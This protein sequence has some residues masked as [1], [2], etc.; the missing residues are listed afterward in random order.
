MAIK[1]LKPQA[2]INT[3]E[4]TGLEPH[5]QAAP[6]QVPDQAALW[7]AAQAAAKSAAAQAAVAQGDHSPQHMKAP[8][9]P[10]KPASFP[11]L[12][13]G[14]EAKKALA[15]EEAKTEMRQRGYIRRWWLPNGKDGSI[16][17]LDGSLQDGMLDIPYYYE[18]NLFINGKYGNFFLCLQD[19]EPC[20]ICQQNNIASYVGVMS[21]IDH[22]EYVSHDGKV[23]KDQRSLFVAKR[24]TVKLLQKIAATC[25]GSLAGM[26]FDVSRIGDKS[27]SVGSMFIPVGP[28]VMNLKELYGDAGVPFNYDDLI[29]NMY[30]SAK[31][32]RHLVVGS[33][34]GPI[35]S[36][37]GVQ[38]DFSGQM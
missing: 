7:A 4:P 9:A 1:F 23:F 3:A 28:R 13:R 2:P 24:D 32:L 34:S 30:V 38:E 37:A 5:Q 10:Q 6:A 33:P 27:P 8:P 12:K 26:R 29:R 25:G 21:V 31:D 15:H 22:S 11:F 36:E 18:H 14:V 17:F 20:P 19:S 16:T 35:G